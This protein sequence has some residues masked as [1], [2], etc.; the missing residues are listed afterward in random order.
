MSDNSLVNTI[1]MHLADSEDTKKMYQPSATMY[2]E[3]KPSLYVQQVKQQ[4]DQDQVE[5]PYPFKHNYGFW[6]NILVCL[7]LVLLIGILLYLTLYRYML[8]GNAI[9]TNHE[10]VAF[11]L[12][13][14]EIA[15]GF[16]TLAA[17]L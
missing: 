11:A 7:F 5:Q 1:K 14:P 10:D 12:L 16:G 3:S 2:P 6:G 13:S 9:S 15:S 8:A 4:K 17:I